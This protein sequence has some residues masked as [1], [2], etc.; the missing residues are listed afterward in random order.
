VDENGVVSF[1]FDSDEGAV[2]NG[3]QFFGVCHPQQTSIFNH[4]QMQV[5]IRY[6][7]VEYLSRI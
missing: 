7:M 2:G 3:Y 1:G 5:Q 6:Q 4:P